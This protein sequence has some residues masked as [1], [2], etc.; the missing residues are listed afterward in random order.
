M[1]KKN[2]SSI[3]NDLL[4]RLLNRNSSRNPNSVSC[5]LWFL[6]KSKFQSKYNTVKGEKRLLARFST[7][8]VPIGGQPGVDFTK[9]CAPSEKTPARRLAK[10]SQFNFIKNIYASYVSRNSP[11]WCAVCQTPLVEKSVKFWKQKSL[12][13]KSDKN[14]ANK[15]GEKAARICWWNRPQVI[16][17][18]FNI[19]YHQPYYL[20]I[21]ASPFGNVL[22][23]IPK[24]LLGFN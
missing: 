24:I 7:L 15:L 17:S 20:I 1:W 19:F 2:H 21:S 9:L 22:L 3:D 14:L 18:L 13:K 12:S 23:W 10:N 11:N 4:K 16:N 6:V 5:F 8:F